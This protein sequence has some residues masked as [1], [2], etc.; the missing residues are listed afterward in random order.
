MSYAV[1]F[2]WGHLNK[3]LFTLDWM[4]MADQGNNS[5]Q[6]CLSYPVSLLAFS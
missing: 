4:L 5:T 2:S 1:D 3:H 6:V